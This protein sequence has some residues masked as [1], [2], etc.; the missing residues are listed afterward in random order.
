[1][2]TYNEERIADAIDDAEEV[3]DPAASEER[4]EKPRLFVENCNPDR[5]SPHSETCSPTPVVYMTAAFRS[6]SPST[7]SSAARSLR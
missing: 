6:A 2:T 3:H 5:R 4:G 1:M 7:R